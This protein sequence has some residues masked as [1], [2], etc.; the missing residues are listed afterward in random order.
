MTSGVMS[1]LITSA[2][3]TE[4]SYERVVGKD[5]CFDPFG[6]HFSEKAECIFEAPI[7]AKTVDDGI[8]C[9]YVR[10]DLSMFHLSEQIQGQGSVPCLSIPS[11]C[12][13]NHLRASNESSS[14]SS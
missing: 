5:I 14:S 10:L 6:F 4:A 1:L 9:D 2:S 7:F 13:Q 12:P 3:I 8:V 11:L